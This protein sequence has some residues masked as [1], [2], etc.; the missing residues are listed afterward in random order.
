MVKFYPS[1]PADLRDWA[2]EQQVF[3][4][5]SAPLAGAHINISPKGLPAATFAFSSPT[6]AAYI[7]ATGSGAETVSHVYENGRVTVMFCSFDGVPRILRLFCWGRVV[8]CG[9]VAGRGGGGGGGGEFERLLARMGKRAFDGARAV[10]LLDIFK[11][12]FC[13]T[14]FFSLPIA[15]FSPLVRARL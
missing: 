8:E 4:V 7:D 15:V 9:V 12:A 6:S 10:V 1:L 2:L 3:F 14:S 5:A 11:G 13:G